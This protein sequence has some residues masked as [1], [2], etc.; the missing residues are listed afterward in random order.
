VWSGR[1]IPVTGIWE[2]WAIDPKIGV[3]C[4]N[5][6]LAG[7]TASQ[8][9]LEGTDT[10]ED[11][12]WRLIWKDSRYM[13]GQTPAEEDEYFTPDLAIVIHAPTMRAVLPGQ[14]CPESGEWFAPH[15]NKTV[16]MVAG[17]TMPGPDRGTTGSVTWY[18]KPHPQASGPR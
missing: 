10:L 17:E 7:D 16:T 18:L 3:R 12:R 11:V 14:I 4:P 8:Y 2:P 15:L 13:S 1:Q 9:Q 5:Y 6:F